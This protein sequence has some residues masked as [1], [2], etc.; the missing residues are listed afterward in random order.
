MLPRLLVLAA[1]LLF[2]TGGVAIKACALSGW[3]IASFRAAIAAATFL[4]LLPDARRGYTR[5]NAAVAVVYAATMILFVNA[6]K[7]TTAANAIFLQST[8]P[9]HVLALGP[10]LLR[11]HLRRDDLVVLSLMAVGLAL[12]FL[13][14]D[15]PSAIA[16]NPWLGNLLGAV[17]GFTFACTMMGMRAIAASRDSA[18]SMLVLGNLFT[19]AVC[20]VMAPQI[21]MPTVADCAILVYLGIFQ[22]AAAYV[23]LSRGLRQV[24]ALEASLL[25]LL[26]PV[27]NPVWVWLVHGEKPAAWA[28]V[29]GVIILAAAT[30]N[31]FRAE[32][33][34][35]ALG[36]R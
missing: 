19:F 7:L 36:K 27:L 12:F 1:A 11:E 30:A 16:A 20:L 23:L 4:L 21:R 9:L 5:R 28:L 25:V 32:T 24:R 17:S 34:G 31:A 10:L 18:S 26:E 15:E 22:I 6:T 3:Q 8:A 33:P 13:G 14:N 35:P 2:S 29:G